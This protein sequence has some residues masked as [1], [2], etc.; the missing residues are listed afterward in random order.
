MWP[1]WLYISIWRY[2]KLSW[3]WIDFCEWREDLCQVFDW[4]DN[5][6]AYQSHQYLWFI[7]NFWAFGTPFSYTFCHFRRVIKL[8]GNSTNNW[9]SETEN[10]NEK[11]LVEKY[12]LLMQKYG[13][14]SKFC[15]NLGKKSADVSK[16]A[17]LF[18]LFFLYFKC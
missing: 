12:L 15:W 11:S 2:F 6:E 3:Y 16:M 7:Q 1:I 8:C 10:W 9:L 17:A 13:N 5:L 18:K 4:L 14:F